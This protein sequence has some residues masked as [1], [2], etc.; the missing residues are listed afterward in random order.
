MDEPL[1]KLTCY[2]CNSPVSAYHLSCP[3]AHYACSHCVKNCY[4]GD[5][6][7]IQ[8]CGICRSDDLI[9]IYQP[10]FIQM[11]K[12]MNLKRT[13]HYADYG[14]TKTSDDPDFDKHIYTCQYRGQKCEYKDC[15]CLIPN[16]SEKIATHYAEDHDFYIISSMMFNLMYKNNRLFFKSY[17]VPISNTN[18]LFIHI[19]HRI[20]TCYSLSQ[21]K[22]NIKVNIGNKSFE[23]LA[24][25]YYD[26]VVPI[27]D[28]EIENDLI[29]VDVQNIDYNHVN[30]EEKYNEYDEYGPP[31]D[32]D[33]DTEEE[34]DESIE[35]LPMIKYT[36]SLTAS[37]A[38]NVIK[39]SA[40]HLLPECIVD[41][42]YELFADF[43][44]NEKCELVIVDIQNWIQNN[45]L[46]Q[47]TFNVTNDDINVKFTLF[48]FLLITENI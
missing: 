27:N 43:L 13:C 32:P 18:V 29:K 1:S 19:N 36:I 3:N 42:V 15:E 20:I 5:Q 46:E 23:L 8:N 26:I 25:N 17:V 28:L 21:P 16:E 41:I 37:D 14:C 24:A 7:R 22:E 12:L 48:D 33:S 11:Y 38:N 45:P 10:I 6:Y 47:I 35:P 30:H 34:E 2:L 4:E 31:P 44:E 9:E 40:A 39:T